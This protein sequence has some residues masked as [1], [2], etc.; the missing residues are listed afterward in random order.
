MMHKIFPMYGAPLQLVTDNRPENGNRTMA[1]VLASL[2][3]VH[4]TMSPY[5]P[6]GN[7]KVE[8][9]HRTLEEVLVKLAR[10]NTEN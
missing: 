9:F 1:E 6:H 7:A 2:N 8:R 10:E 5:H 4:I 3:T